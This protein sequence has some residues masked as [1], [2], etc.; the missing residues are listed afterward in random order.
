MRWLCRYGVLALVAAGCAQS[1]SAQSTVGELVDRGAAALDPAALRELLPGADFSGPSST[2]TWDL[3]L[4]PD[5]ALSGFQIGSPVTFPVKGDWSIDEAGRF[6][7]FS[8]GL[9]GYRVRKCAFVFKLGESHYL[10][11][12]AD[13]RKEPASR[14]RFAR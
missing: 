6:C 2:V 12:T 8:A 14:V 5:G 4:W 7:F 10:A 1:A 11:R 13:E 3:H 9:R